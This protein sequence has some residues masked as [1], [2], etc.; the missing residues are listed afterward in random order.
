MKESCSHLIWDVPFYVRRHFRRKGNQPRADLQPPA[1]TECCLLL[2]HVAREQM[3]EDTLLP[4]QEES[5]HQHRSNCPQGSSESF[6]VSDES[7]CSNPNSNGPHKVSAQLTL[8]N[9]VWT[10]PLYTWVF[11]CFSVNTAV[12]RILE[13]PIHRWV[14]FQIETVFSHSQPQVENTVCSLGWEGPPVVIQA[15]EESEVTFLAVQG[16]VPLIPT[17]FKGQL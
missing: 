8:N 7:P 14:P 16:S 6:K 4:F 10:D 9:T 17:Y 2:E 1:Q 13:F 11:V 5:P 12:P 15:S 3:Q